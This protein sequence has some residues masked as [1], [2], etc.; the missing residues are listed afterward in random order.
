MKVSKPFSH[1]DA[2]GKLHMVDVSGKAPTRRTSHASCRVITDIDIA[3]LK[4]GDFDPVH[5]ARVAGILAAKQTA[6]LIPLCH[7]ID[8][9]DVQVEVAP[10]SG[11]LEIEA[12]VVTVDHTG[13]EMEALVACALTALGIVNALLDDDPSAHVE[14]LVLLKKTGGKSGDWGQLVPPV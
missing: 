8:I 3:E 4:S 12:K 9:S 11:G 13:V 6:I 2:A 10:F 1:V 7:P 14:D 5:A